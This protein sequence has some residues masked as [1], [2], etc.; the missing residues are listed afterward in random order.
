MVFMKN[1]NNKGLRLQ[2]IL[3]GILPLITL[4][5]VIGWILYYIGSQDTVPTKILKEQLI[6]QKVIPKDDGEPQAVKQQI[7]A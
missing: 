7:L 4:F 3:L 6:F 2:P 5:W 1:S